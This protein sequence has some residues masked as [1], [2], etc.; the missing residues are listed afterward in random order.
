M[1]IIDGETERGKVDMVYGRIVTIVDQAATN[2]GF[3]KTQ[4]AV[5]E[6]QKHRTKPH[7][8]GKN[9]VHA[10]QIQR[11]TLWG[12]W[13]ETEERQRRTQETRDRT[14][15]DQDEQQQRRDAEKKRRNTT[16]RGK[17]RNGDRNNA[18]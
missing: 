9:H 10:T 14:G 2:A 13:E 7:Q 15:Q 4:Y 6:K 11:R 12:E 5:R 17:S 3:A 8:A 16:N 18:H 1:G